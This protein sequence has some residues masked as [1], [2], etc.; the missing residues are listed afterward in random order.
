ME[1]TIFQYPLVF[2]YKI[3]MILNFFFSQGINEDF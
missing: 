2:A 1:N 3:E